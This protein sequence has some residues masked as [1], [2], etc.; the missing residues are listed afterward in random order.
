M[1]K[2]TIHSRRASC[3][4]LFMLAMCS[5]LII[6][7]YDIALY[8]NTSKQVLSGQYTRKN[9]VAQKTGLIYDTQGKLISHKIAGAVAVVNPASCRDKNSAAQ[10]IGKYSSLSFEEILTKISIPEPF[11]VTFNEVPET[12]SPEGIYVYPAFEEMANNFCRHLLGYK[13]SDGRGVDGVYGKFDSIISTFSGTL[14]YSYASD[15]QGRVLGE[16]DFFVT[17]SGYT[18]ASG[19]V[20]TIDSHLQRGIDNLCDKYMDM[21]AVVVCEIDT[22]NILALSSRPLYEAENVENVLDSDR[23]EL[24]N[25][26]FSLYTPGSVFKTAVAAAALETDPLLLNFEY[27]CTGE[28][29]VSG[30]IFKCH[31][32]HGHGKQSM[33]EAYANSCNTYF[34]RLAQEIGIGQICAFTEKIGIG[35]INPLDGMSVKKANMPEQFKKYPPAYLANFSFGQGEIMTSPVDILN[36]FCVC[37]SGEKIDFTLA[38]GIYNSYAEEM[39]YFTS[40]KAQRVLSEDTVESLC[41]MMKLCVTNGTGK[42]AMSDAVSVGGKTATAQSGQYDSDGNELLHRW[43]AGVFPIEN[44]KYAAV[45]LYDGNGKNSSSPA[46]FFSKIAELMY[47]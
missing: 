43:F 44:P 7:L 42:S 9:V 37:S 32:T 20:L 33:P 6:R 14:F 3:V 39:T 2:G 24:I 4:F 30:K 35:E 15:A 29:D 8:D 5:A 26:A 46:E 10:Y 25:R 21:G 13:D 19:L 16:E 18:D 11:T 28:C 23:G 34:I 47:N 38:K 17:D 36:L 27:E 45:V 41:S 12:E 31:E 40:G 22:G 1:L